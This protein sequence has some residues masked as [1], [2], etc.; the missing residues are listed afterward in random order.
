MI[1]ASGPAIRI[2]LIPVPIHDTTNITIPALMMF[3][4]ANLSIPE[5]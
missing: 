5:N 4:S 2:N 1:N 3:P